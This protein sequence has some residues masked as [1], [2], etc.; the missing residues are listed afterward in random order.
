MVAV[1]A[2]T[3]VRLRS[4]RSAQARRNGQDGPATADGRPSWSRRDPDSRIGGGPAGPEAARGEYGSM[5]ATTGSTE[6]VAT[7]ATNGAWSASGGPTSVAQVIETG[8][9]I[10][11]K[12]SAPATPKPGSDGATDSSKRIDALRSA[13]EAAERSRRRVEN[14]FA[15]MSSEEIAE[16]LNI[17]ENMEWGPEASLMFQG[18]VLRWG[19]LN[20]LEALDYAFAFESKRTRN[21]A[22]S[23]ALQGWSREDAQSAFNWFVENWEDNPSALGMSVGSL[24]R[25]MV[26]HDM[27]WAFNQVWQLPTSGLQKSALQTVMDKM[28]SQRDRAYV[29]ASYDELQDSRQRAMMADAIVKNI[30]RYNPEEA[31]AWVDSLEDPVARNVALSRLVSSWAY[32]RPL[33][34]ADY[35]STI[36]DPAMRNKQVARLISV[37]SRDDPMAASQWLNQFPPSRSLDSAVAS[38]VNNTCKDDPEGA[39]DWAESIASRPLRHNLI[40]R[41]AWEWVKKDYEV[42]LGYIISS[43]LPEKTKKRFLRRAAAHPPQQ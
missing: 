23:K 13:I 31:A 26:S 27:D 42:A 10:I 38:L 33:A 36:P 18:L 43:E 8:I 30:S 14:L 41:V 40:Q 20:P 2:V 7:A 22:V 6:W 24:F 25:N 35:V 5:Q 37:W 4:G 34:A 1:V 11:E 39:M 12:A 21:A 16:A 9:A 28:F 3:V 29:L 19:S 15:S 17:V 32:D